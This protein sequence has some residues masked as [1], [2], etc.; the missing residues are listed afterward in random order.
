MTTGP[1]AKAAGEIMESAGRRMSIDYDNGK[2]VTSIGDVAF[3]D[4]ILRAN[5]AHYLPLLRDAVATITMVCPT[6]KRLLRDALNDEIDRLEKG[7][8]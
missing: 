1:E 2:M 4:I 7:A 6:N 5:A 3:A 8:A